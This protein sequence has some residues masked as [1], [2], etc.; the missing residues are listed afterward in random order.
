MTIILITS[1]PVY[2]KRKNIIYNHSG[3]SGHHSGA[4]GHHNQWR[5]RNLCATV[6]PSNSARTLRLLLGK[7]AGTTSL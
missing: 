5:C 6:G 1:I 7:A 3:A 2:N 4:S